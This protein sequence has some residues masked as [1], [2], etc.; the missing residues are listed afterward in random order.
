MN[1]ILTMV[2]L[3]AT[4]S[5]VQAGDA[6]FHV[7]VDMVQLRVT[8][9]DPEGRYIENLGAKDFRVLENGTQRK[10]RSVIA[11]A[12]TAQSATTVYV[13]FDT[14]DR[15]YDDFC[16]A[17]DAVADF[18]RGL[19]PSDAVAVYSFSRNLTRLAEPTRDRLQTMIGLRH[20]VAGDDT[21]LYDSMVLTLRDA[22][23]VAGNKVIVVFSRGHDKSSM[24]TPEQVRS[25]AEDEGVPIYVVSS[26]DRSALSQAAFA[27]L[28]ANTGGRAYFARTWQQ[29]TMA[30]ESIDQDL[31]HSYVLTYYV[32][33]DEARSFRRIEVQI[34]SDRAHALRVRTRSGYE[35]AGSD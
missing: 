26:R 13:L 17:E 33:P 27:D 1:R 19:A 2:A 21:S 30:L 10:I 18:I 32:P 34:P 11:P 15:M 5:T 35:P 6:D 29:Q 24:L 23:R 14:S 28:A 4:W 9:T 7:N 3:A 22:A 25:I 12:Q 16:F 8:I 20:A 31:N